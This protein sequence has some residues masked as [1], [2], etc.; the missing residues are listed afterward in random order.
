MNLKMSACIEAPKERAREV[1]S[2]V[3]NDPLWVGPILSAHCEGS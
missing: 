3:T 1:L 2:D